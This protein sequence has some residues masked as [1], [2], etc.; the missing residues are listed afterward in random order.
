MKHVFRTEM[1]KNIQDKGLIFWT[2]LLPIIF[3]VLFIA[4]FTANVDEADQAAVTTSIVP[5]YAVMFVFFIMISMGT[6]FLEDRDKGMIARLAGTPLTPLQYVS[7]KWMA[8]LLIV[9]F[10]III[11]QMFGRIVYTIPIEQPFFI[12]IV[13]FTLAFCATGLGIALS[14]LIRTNNM[15]IAITQVVALGGAIIGGLWMP[16]DMMPDFIQ[17]LSR[18]TPQ[19]W[20]HIGLKEAMAGTATY[21]DTII[22]AVILVGFGCFGLLVSVL[23]YP[24]FL[25]RAKN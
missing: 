7:G 3:T 6:S 19:Y 21:Q 22:S 13:S 25:R 23:A 4:I 10:Q 15:G 12:M 8:Y 16:L 1:L 24:A 20:A 17:K 14:V 2:L 18:L 9:L 11:L 5:G